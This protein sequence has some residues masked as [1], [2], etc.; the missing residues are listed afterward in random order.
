MN[1]CAPSDKQHHKLLLDQSDRI[2]LF[3][4]R[5]IGSDWAQL[6]RNASEFAVAASKTPTMIALARQGPLHQAG[7][8]S[9]VFRFVFLRHGY[10]ALNPWPA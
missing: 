1:C 3:L 6:D 10:L 2:S 7:V 4:F 5:K 9:V 8:S